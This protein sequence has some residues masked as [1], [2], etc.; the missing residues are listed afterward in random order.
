MYIYFIFFSI[1]IYLF[2]L[3]VF[4]DYAHLSDVATTGPASSDDDFEIEVQSKMPI[5]AKNNKQVY[6]KF[7][8]L[9]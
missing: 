2:V 4:E 8:S 3:Q 7:L 6:S 9:S 5:Y 1:E